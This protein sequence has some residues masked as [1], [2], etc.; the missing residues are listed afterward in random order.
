MR[1][2]TACW[3]ASAAGSAGCGRRRAPPR[4]TDERRHKKGG[5]GGGGSAGAPSSTVD[6]AA[7]GQAQLQANVGTAETQAQLN[8][9]NTFSPYGSTVYQAGAIDPTTGRPSSWAVEQRLSDPLQSLFNTQTGLAYNLASGA[10]P[11]AGYAPQLGSMG[12][13]LLQRGANWAGQLPQNLDL[14]AVPNVGLLS[15]SSFQTNVTTGAGGQALPGVQTGITNVPGLQ[16]A[17]NLSG[18]QQIQQQ[19]GGTGFIPGLV[20]QAQNAAYQSQ[21]QY[22]DPQFAHAQE[23]LKQQLADQGIEEGSP[24]YS[25][26]IGDFGRQQQQ[27]YSN[28]S[29]N[30][31]QAGNAQEQALY[32][33]ALQGGE[34]ANQAQAQAFGQQMGLTGLYN[35]AQ[36]QAYAQQMG[37]AQLANQAQ[38][39]MFGQGMSLADLYNQAQ[40]GAAQQNL[41]A[42]AGN[43]AR[44]Q[45]GFQA[46]FSAA[47]E[48]AQLGGGMYGQGL[49]SL[50]QLLPAV[51]AW[52]TGATGIP[53]LAPGTA[54]G[55]SPANIVGAQQAATGQGY[56]AQQARQQGLNNLLGGSALG[57]QALTGNSLG[58]LFGSGGGGGLFGGGGLLGSL[59]GGGAGAGSAAASLASGADPLAAAFDA[60]FPLI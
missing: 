4:L 17:P 25:Q 11:Y 60:A 21:T 5:G 46:P 55:V 27:A 42:Q 51:T 36:Q 56:L 54:T 9:L 6:P 50:S 28:A 48:L 7:L 58:G 32:G 39:Q 16:Y 8:N 57:Y 45:A 24:A 37:Q 18:V 10:G 43:L 15:P 47:S 23:Q 22:L 35:Q 34:F 40:L 30:A 52:P 33:Q 44:A 53:N 41:Q 2:A 20:N 31:I 14:S 19:V 59:F 1:F 12:M 13:N 29:M 3:P 38:A 49:G 26:A